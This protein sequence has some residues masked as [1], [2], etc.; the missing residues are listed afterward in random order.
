MSS[1]PTIPFHL[2][3]SCIHE[4]RPA[5]PV[6]WWRTICEV[7]PR[8]FLSGGLSHNRKNALEQLNNW[9]AAGVTHYIAV[10]E[11]CDDRAFIHA[12]SN[13]TCIRVG[14]DDNGT[15]RDPQWFEE[16]TS[17]ACDILKDPNAV[18]MVTCWMGANRGP[19]AAFAILLATGWK[20]L[21]ALRA[22]RGARPIAGIIYAPDAAEWWAQRNGASQNEA[23]AARREVENWF[24]RNPL[25][26]H[27]VIRSIGSR[28]GI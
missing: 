8:V 12:N 19:S 26:L 23:I 11:E 24:D 4:V 6:Q 9:S 27:F 10:H 25:D 17:A 7:T 5:D 13:I 18:L 21:P 28:T 20:A 3:Q 22:I 2:E 1:T 15:P 14:V 16:V